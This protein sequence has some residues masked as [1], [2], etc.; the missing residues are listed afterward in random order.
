[1]DKGGKEGKSESW[2][3][4]TEGE[5]TVGVGGEL[6]RGGQR[7]KNRNNCNRTTIKYL[8]K[9]KSLQQRQKLQFLML[10]L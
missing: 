10:P 5:L 4:T 7:G 9:K 3:W 2:S 6:G 1:M 8:K